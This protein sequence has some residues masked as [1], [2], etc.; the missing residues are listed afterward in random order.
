M[1]TSAQVQS[2]RAMQLLHAEG[3]G[4]I[5]RDIE[6]GARQVVK[7]VDDIRLEDRGADA[8]TEFLAIHL[9]A[10]ARR[11]S[12]LARRIRLEQMGATRDD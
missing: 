10:M 11:A 8:R 4:E 2:H 12:K 6:N 9:D 7:L 3:A 5:L 1:S